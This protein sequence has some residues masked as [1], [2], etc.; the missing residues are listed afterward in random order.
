MSKFFVG[1]RVRIIGAGSFPQIIGC[2]CRITKLDQVSLRIYD[3]GTDKGMVQVDMPPPGYPWM[4]LCVKPEWLE[5]ILPEGSAPSEY[6]FQQLM[7]NL[8]EV[9][10]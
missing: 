7:D 1:Q 10:A 8:Q 3:G 4:H 2:E 6:T 5:P 9:M